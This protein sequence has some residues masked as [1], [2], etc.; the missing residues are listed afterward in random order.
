MSAA[1]KITLARITLIPLLLVF[2]VHEGTTVDRWI[3]LAIFLLASATDWLDGYVARSRGQVT[4]LG[5]LLD[6]VADKLLV[7]AALLPLV[8]DELV[9]DWMAALLIGREFL[10]TGLRSVASAEGVV[11][12]AGAVGKWKMGMSITAISFLIVV[13]NP[14]A[15]VWPRWVPDGA[16]LKLGSGFLW[17][18][19]ALSLASAALYFWEYRHFIQVRKETP[20]AP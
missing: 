5:K 11:I 4:V 19:L 14:H 12:P 8:R 7:T 3:A 9:S 10:V 1:N 13:P 17:A 20:A 16:Y 6:P 18:T 15:P 2:L